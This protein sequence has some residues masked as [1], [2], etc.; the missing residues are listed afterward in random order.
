[1]AGDLKEF[2]NGLK[3]CTHPQVYLIFLKVLQTKFGGDAPAGSVKVFG[4]DSFNIIIK[5]IKE[6]LINHYFSARY[7]CFK[8]IVRMLANYVISAESIRQTC[9]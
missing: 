3:D 4:N 8:Y 2:M 5:M 7:L 1:M 9:P 6:E